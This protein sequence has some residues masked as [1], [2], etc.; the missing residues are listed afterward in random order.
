M[1]EYNMVNGKSIART[2]AYENRKTTEA[3]RLFFTAVLFIIVT[4]CF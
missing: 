4:Q 1:K 3:F 2:V